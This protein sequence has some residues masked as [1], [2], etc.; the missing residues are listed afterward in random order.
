MSGQHA[1]RPP[2]ST[3]AGLG[4]STGDMLLMAFAIG[5]LA[6]AFLHYAMEWLFEVLR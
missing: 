6:G 2:R 1:E 4:L 3:R 5:V